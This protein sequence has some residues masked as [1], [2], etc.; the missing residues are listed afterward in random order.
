LFRVAGHI[1]EASAGD[2]ELRDGKVGVKGAPGL[3]KTIAEIA[4]TA[5]L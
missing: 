4:T 5:S 1:L 3:E 2:L